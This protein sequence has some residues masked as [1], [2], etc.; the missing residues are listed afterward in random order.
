MNELFDFE[1]AEQL[2]TAAAS[3][4]L[5]RNVSN[6]NPDPNRLPPLQQPPFNISLSQ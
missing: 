5:S 6:A 4:P 2:I 1:T 3:P